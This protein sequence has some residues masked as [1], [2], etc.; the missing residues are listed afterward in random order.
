M[1]PFSGEGGVGNALVTGELAANHIIAEKT[2]EEYQAEMEKNSYPELTNS[3]RM[4]KL[5]RK[6]GC[7]I[8]LLARRVRSHKYKK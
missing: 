2:P 8:G 7:L 4:Q 6:N 5:S 3:Y 1:D